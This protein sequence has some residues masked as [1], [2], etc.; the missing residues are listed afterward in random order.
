VRESEYY[1]DMPIVPFETLPDAARVWVFGS[2][3]ALAG[4]DADRLLGEV[5]RFLGQWK[6][7]GVPLFCARDWRDEH[8]LTIGVDSTR[9]NASGC[10][11]DGLFRVLQA[12]ERPLGTKLVGGG[13]VFY[14]DGRGAV[15]C[16]ARDELATRVARGDITDDTCIFDT[17]VTNAGEWRTR[18]EAPASATWVGTFLGS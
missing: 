14:R 9:E 15:Q 18:F 13:R 3:R 4:S 5:D 12:I 11:I 10:S 8:L 7:H 16:A 2:G 1:F 17:S 6:A